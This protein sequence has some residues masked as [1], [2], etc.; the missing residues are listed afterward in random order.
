[1]MTFPQFTF[2]LMSCLIFRFPLWRLTCK[3]LEW[4]SSVPG[5]QPSSL[6]VLP[7][8]SG[9]PIATLRWVS[10]YLGPMSSSVLVYFLNLVGLAFSTFCEG[11]CGSSV[12]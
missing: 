11:V 4:L 6:D 3:N 1:M 10:H 12:F 9:G 2:F 7:R 8:C 5:A